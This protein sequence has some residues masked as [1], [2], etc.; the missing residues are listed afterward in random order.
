MISQEELQAVLHYDPE[1]GVFTRIGQRHLLGQVA[2]GLDESTGYITISVRNR[3]YYAH[4][5]AVLYM[6]SVWPKSHTDHINGI[7]TDNRFVNL[8]PG[9]ARSNAANQKKHRGGHLAGTS[10]RARA[11][12]WRASLQLNLGGGGRS[13][14]HIGYFRT[15]E[16]AHAAY[17]DSLREWDF[18]SYS[19]IMKGK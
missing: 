15:Q 6:T 13:T 2:G 5:L 12:D 16:A 11:R 7:K 19:S 18:A 9:T 14:I 17:L 8:E 3:K 10:Y 1:T 4:R